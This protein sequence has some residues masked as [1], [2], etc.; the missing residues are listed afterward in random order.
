MEDENGFELLGQSALRGELLLALKEEQALTLEDIMRRRLDLE[1]L[2]GHGV[3][4]LSHICALMA[5]NRSAADVEKE[6]KE[7]RTRLETLQKL[8]RGEA[9]A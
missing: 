9:T 4:A 2:P 6:Q 5:Q 7:Y 8:L 1:Y 3:E